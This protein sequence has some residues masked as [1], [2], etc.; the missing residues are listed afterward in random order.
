MKRTVLLTAICSCI[1]SFFWLA[2]AGDNPQ[3]VV[4]DSGF[5][6]FGENYR[7]SRGEM[8]TQDCGNFGGSCP[9]GYE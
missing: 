5:T 4:Q 6:Y 3:L 9:G 7:A 1:F 8:E 2:Q